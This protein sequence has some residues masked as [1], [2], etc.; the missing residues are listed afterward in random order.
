MQ[1][2]FSSESPMQDIPLL[3]P[4][5]AD[6]LDTSNGDHKNLSGNSPLLSQKLEHETLVSDTQMK[7]FQVEVV[8]YL[9]AQPVVVAL[10][11]CRCKFFIKGEKVYNGVKNN[12]FV[13]DMPCQKPYAY[14]ERVIRSVSQWSAGTSQ[15]EESIHTAYCSLI[16]EAKHFIYIEIS[17]KMPYL[18]PSTTCHF[19]PPTPTSNPSTSPPTSLNAIS[20]N[21]QRHRRRRRTRKKTEGECKLSLVFSVSIQTPTVAVRVGVG[22]DRDRGKFNHLRVTD[23]SYNNQRHRKRRRTRKKIEGECRLSLVFSVSIQ[24]PTVVVRV[25]VGIDGDRAFIGSSNINGHNFLGLRDSKMGVIIEDKEYVESLMNG[26]PWK[27]G[28]F[29]YRLRCSLWQ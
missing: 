15:P 13:D 19:S 6:G 11:N 12:Y 2:S 8:P 7:G 21:N 18:A 26:K 20:Y 4:Q 17:P 25:G 22:I 3:L 9:G 1:D 24:T 28:K 27:A 16:E 5:E 14:T 23:F 10:D 29:S